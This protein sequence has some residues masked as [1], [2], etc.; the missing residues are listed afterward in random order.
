MTIQAMRAFQMGKETTRGTAVAATARLVGG[1]D[2]TPIDEVKRDDTPIGVLSEVRGGRDIVI[3]KGSEIALEMAVSYEQL[4]YILLMGV[5]GGVVGVGT[6][7]TV[8]TFLAPET[9]D[10]A[11]TTFTMEAQITDGTTPLDVEIPYVFCPEFTISGALG[12]M[13]KIKAALVGRALATST[14]TPALTFPTVEQIPTS[15]CKVYIDDTWAGLGGTQ[16]SAQVYSFD[17][18]YKTGLG[19]G[20]RIDGRASMDF[21]AYEFG[22]HSG[23]LGI[24]LE[25]KT[26]AAAERAKAA[27]QALRFV[28]ISAAGSGTKELII[29]M[30]CKHAKGDFWID[31]APQGPNDVASLALVLA[32]DPTSAKSFQVVVKNAIVTLP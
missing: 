28:R 8:W 21:T 1:L 12:D 14:F 22:P 11:P 26:T 5:K 17:G 18:N 24:V 25:W 31:P 9:A 10:P 23:T 16:V 7:P 32:Y 19:I 13:L 20:E 29:D 4:M 2:I 6:A 3:R 27:S 15:L 30:A